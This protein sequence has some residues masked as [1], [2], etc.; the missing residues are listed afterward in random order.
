MKILRRSERCSRRHEVN[1]TTRSGLQFQR[2]R[3]CPE[4][5]NRVWPL[6]DGPRR[7]RRDHRRLG[8]GIESAIEAKD[9]L[10]T[11]RGKQHVSPRVVLSVDLP[12]FIGRLW[13]STKFDRCSQPHR[14]SICALLPIGRSL[15][16]PCNTPI[17]V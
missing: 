9:F 3:M 11:L 10:S 17:A 13:R 6:T 7:F 1:D 8:V 4:R 2:A 12:A 5:V 16:V 14:A 15:S